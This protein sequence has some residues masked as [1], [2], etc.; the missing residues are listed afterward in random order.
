MAGLDGLFIGPGDL[1]LSLGRGPGQD[2]EEPELTAAFAALARRL[3]AAGKRAASMP[4]RRLRRADGG[5][6]F[7]LVTV[8][9][10]VVAIASTLAAAATTW[11][12]Q[13]GS[14]PRPG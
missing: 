2:R 10:D 12:E 8:W 9:V 4:A 3:C 14:L 6:G 13:A 1:G 5:Q 7:D 11:T